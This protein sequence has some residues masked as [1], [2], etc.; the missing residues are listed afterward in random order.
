MP[1]PPPAVYQPKPVGII[2]ASEAKRKINFEL[3]IEVPAKR[4]KASL[5]PTPNSS[6]GSSAASSSRNT[7]DTPVVAATRA[8][9][10]EPRSSPQN[11]PPIHDLQGTTI[12]IDLDP[13]IRNIA[14]TRKFM[15]DHFGAHPRLHFAQPSQ[16]HIEEH[17]YDHFV[18]LREVR[19]S[20]VFPCPVAD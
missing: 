16:E 15:W 2:P 3:I 7:L 19:A 13:N 12:K 6:S 11:E 14:V 8:P 5:Y 10:K 1:P 4:L 18:F 17:G 20:K 9:V